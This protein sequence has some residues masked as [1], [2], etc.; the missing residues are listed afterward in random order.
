MRVKREL[1]KYVLYIDDKCYHITYTWHKTRS[2]ESASLLDSKINISSSRK[3]IVRWKT[4]IFSITTNSSSGME[5][6]YA[7]SQIN[8]TKVLTVFV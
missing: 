4:F 7:F 3:V 5:F 2:L 6:F 8:Y 1:E